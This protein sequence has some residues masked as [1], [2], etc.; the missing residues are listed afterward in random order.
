MHLVIGIFNV[1]AYVNARTQ[2]RHEHQ[3]ESQHWKLTLERKKSLLHQEVELHQQRTGPD[4]PPPDL[5]PRSGAIA[6][7]CNGHKTKRTFGKI[8]FCKPIKEHGASAMS[9]S[10]SPAR[11]PVLFYF[12]TTVSALAESAFSIKQFQLLAGSC[13]L[14][15]HQLGHTGVRFLFCCC[16]NSSVAFL[17][18]SSRGWGG[19]GGGGRGGWMIILYYTRIKI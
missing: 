14:I 8:K 1:H 12:F 4:A 3:K 7:P 13:K 9:F 16:H 2:G 17:S 6:V 5:H 11:C 10:D 15:P 18:P 19:G